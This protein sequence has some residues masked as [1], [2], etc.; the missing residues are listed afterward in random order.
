MAKRKPKKRIQKKKAVQKTAQK[1]RD[2]GISDKQQKRLPKT[3]KKKTIQKINKTERAK[4][5][6]EEKR[7]Y[8]ENHGITNYSTNGKNYNS[9]SLSNLSWDKINE[10]IAEDSK[11]KKSVKNQQ[12][13]Q[14]TIKNKKRYALDKGLPSTFLIKNNMTYKEIDKYVIEFL[15]DRTVYKSSEFLSVLWSDVT[16]E[17]KMDLALTD[18]SYMSTSEMIDKIHEIQEEAEG[19]TPD[20]SSGFLGVASIVWGD[21]SEVHDEVNSLWWR[22]YNQKT[23]TEVERIM[24]SN[25][26][27][28]RGYANMMLSVMTRT[29]AEF[30]TDYYNNFET[31]AHKYLPEIHKQIFK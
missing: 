21:K 26:F 15:G 30:I 31:F 24:Y 11:R 17:S 27:T 23:P 13:R 9:N 19:T 12:Y 4:A 6:K 10:I 1:L 25:E 28:V 16:G 22:G 14:N 29:K 18:F 20:D 3:E 2:Y 7:L 5:L 8:L